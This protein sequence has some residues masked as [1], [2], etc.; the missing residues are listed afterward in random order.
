M[1]VTGTS[2]SRGDPS[3]PGDTDT[4]RWGGGVVQGHLR[5]PRGVPP[6]FPRCLPRCPPRCHLV[7]PLRPAPHDRAR[8]RGGSDAAAPRSHDVAK[9]KKAG[10][11]RE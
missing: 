3:Q 7:R 2:L 10:E 5:C 1:P 9:K 11:G 4:P 8:A 6:G